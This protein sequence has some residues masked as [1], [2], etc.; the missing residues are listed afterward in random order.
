M[1]A[2]LL[3]LASAAGFGGSDYAAGLAA[4]RASVIRITIL[5]E[6]VSVVFLILVLPLAGLR[7]PSLASL[8]C[9]LP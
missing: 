7:A 9:P 4:R 1:L 3:A 6:A 5:A 2:V 8:G